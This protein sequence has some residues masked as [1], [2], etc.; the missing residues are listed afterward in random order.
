FIMAGT[1]FLVAGTL[2]YA[3]MRARGA[4]RPTRAQWLGAALVGALLLAGGNGAVVWSEQRVA[5]GIAALLVAVVPFWMVLLDWLRPGGRRPRAKV[6]L[7]IVVGFSGLALLIGPGQLRGAGVDLVGIGVLLVGTLLWATG[8]LLSRGLPR[9]SAPLLG[10]AMQMLVGGVILL[11][12]GTV[13]G[14]AGRIAL[15]DVSARSLVALAYLV[16]FGSLI[17]YS[18]YVW[19]LQVAPASVVSTYAYVNPVIAVFLGWLV[20]GETVTARTIVA[21]AVII[22]AVGLI[23]LSRP[24]APA[25]PPRPPSPSASPRPR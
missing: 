21:A 15:H 12:L 14:E 17:A 3:V 8:S 25:S 2:L 16:V 5:S 9:P 19:L 23:N 1:R 11:A 4:P 18:C 6:W 10:V 22:G 7:G 24:R 13:T 20:A